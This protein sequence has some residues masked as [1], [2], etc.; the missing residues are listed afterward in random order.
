MVPAFPYDQGMGRLNTVAT[1]KLQKVHIWIDL[2]N[3]M[4]YR[5]VVDIFLEKKKIFNH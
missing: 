1:T 5:K 3:I 4:T 2:E